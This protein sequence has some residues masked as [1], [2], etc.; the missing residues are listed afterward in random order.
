MSFKFI[1]RGAML[2]LKQFRTWVDFDTDCTQKFFY[3]PTIQPSY[4]PSNHQINHLLN[5]TQFS[6][7]FPP[8]FVSFSKLLNRQIYG[9]TQ[10]VTQFLSLHQC[11]F[12]NTPIKFQKS[13]FYN[14][15]PKINRNFKFQ[16]TPNNFQNLIIPHI[17]NRQR[18]YTTL[19][20]KIK[21]M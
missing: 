3:R 16:S 6:P 10:V 18:S 21:H 20:S 15:L 7:V 2:V 19:S 12:F 1:L 17:E 14:K 5:C 13:I 4:Q 11:N 9:S 8:H